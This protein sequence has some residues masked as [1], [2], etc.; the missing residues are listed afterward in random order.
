MLLHSARS[1]AQCGHVFV[2][3]MLAGRSTVLRDICPG[4]CQPR[5]FCSVLP[6]GRRH[7]AP[8][9]AP[10][11]SLPP[12]GQRLMARPTIWHA[13]VGAMVTLVLAYIHCHP[14]IKLAHRTVVPR[15]TNNPNANIHRNANIAGCPKPTATTP[16]H[17]V[18]PQ[19]AQGACDGSPARW[20]HA[21]SVHH[22]CPRP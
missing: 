6:P 2:A 5:L 4:A 15:A 8:T 13:G 11:A 18:S 14:T 1:V 10:V 17:V 3:C 16:P 20:P 12:V 21:G 22:L 19:P 9:R 7:A